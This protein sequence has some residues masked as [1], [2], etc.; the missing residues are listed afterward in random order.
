MGL[1]WMTIYWVLRMTMFGDWEPVHRRPILLY[2]LG[3]LLL[4]V[5]LLCMGFLAELI[6]A[7][8]TE[9]HVPYSITEREQ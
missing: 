3:A 5:Q 2:S 1:V 6:V 8:N 7:R 9:Q 4:V